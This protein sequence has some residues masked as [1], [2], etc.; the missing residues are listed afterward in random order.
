MLDKNLNE[1]QKHIMQLLCTSNLE[2]IELAE[3]LALAIDWDIEKWLKANSYDLFEL[4]LPSN[5]SSTCSIKLTT[6]VLLL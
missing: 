1:D 2:N 6:K 4:G 5:F 3:I